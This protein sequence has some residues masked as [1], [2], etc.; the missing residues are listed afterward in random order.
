MKHFSRKCLAASLVIAAPCTVAAADGRGS[1]QAA[2]FAPQSLA[3]RQGESVPVKLGHAQPIKVPRWQPGAEQAL[4]TLR[5]SIRRVELPK[6]QKLIALT[7]DLCEQ[8]SEI[9]GYDGAIVDYLRLNKIKATFFGGGKWMATHGERTQQIMSD[10]LFEIGTHGWAHRNVRGISGAD[11]Q[12]E[13]MTPSAAY[14]QQRQALADTQ[15]AAGHVAA[16]QSIARQPSLY[17]FPFGA[18]NPTALD[19]VAA[20]G[21]LAIQWDVSTGDPAP[22]QSAKAIA[23]VMI[24]HTRP[25]SIILAHANGRGF[26]TADA[27]PLAIPVLR[28]KG[29]QF[30]T[31]SELLAAGQ[32]VVSE[33][34]YDEKPGDSDKYDALFAPRARMNSVIGGTIEPPPRGSGSK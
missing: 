33:T 25:G 22:N 17:R 2:C 26:H 31:V 23:E 10:D 4:N 3:A 8:W 27:L 13:L 30:V 32:P 24:K 15:C 6:G 1:V 21:L 20:N 16:M 12:R 14:Q 19:A 7:F 18:C 11:L 28:Q 5:G 34:C 9:A 29:Y